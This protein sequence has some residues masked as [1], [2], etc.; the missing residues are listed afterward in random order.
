MCV[1]NC[2]MWMPDGDRKR[3]YYYNNTQDSKTIILPTATI[4]EANN[5][6]IFYFI[7]WQKRFRAMNFQK[8]KI[9][10]NTIDIALW[11]GINYGEWQAGGEEEN[12]GKKALGPI[13]YIVYYIF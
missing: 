8:K 9:I 5:K 13:K 1:G 7:R 4:Q 11:R 6:Y 10:R 2:G 3:V 12:N